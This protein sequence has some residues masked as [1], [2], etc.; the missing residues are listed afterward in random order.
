MV[1]KTTCH[2]AYKRREWRL[3]EGRGEGRST[4]LIRVSCESFSLT[5][6]CSRCL[7]DSGVNSADMGMTSPARIMIALRKRGRQNRN[8]YFSRVTVHSSSSSSSSVWRLTCCPLRLPHRASR[9]RRRPPGQCS[10][11][12]CCRPPFPFLF[13]Y[14]EHRPHFFFDSLLHSS[15]AFA[16]YTNKIKKL[17]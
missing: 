14:P 12:R 8:A 10:L 16:K 5:R 1:G 4:G 15:M 6:N 9:A 7:S 3:W 17:P 13:A 11:L 2:A